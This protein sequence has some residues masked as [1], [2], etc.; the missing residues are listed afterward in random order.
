MNTTRPQLG[1]NTEENP[2]QKAERLKKELMAQVRDRI[3]G[4]PGA[5]EL[6][7]RFEEILEGSG[8]INETMA[9]LTDSI[10]L[11]ADG[12]IWMYGTDKPVMSTTLTAIVGMYGERMAAKEEVATEAVHE[13]I[14]AKETITRALQAARTAYEKLAEVTSTR[15]FV[16]AHLLLERALELQQEHGA[17]EQLSPFAYT[18]DWLGIH[19]AIVGTMQTHPDEDGMITVKTEYS[20]GLPGVQT[21]TRE[22]PLILEFIDE[23]IALMG[24]DLSEVL[25]N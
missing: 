14:K 22:I 19:E 16:E 21:I 15:H 11:N 2:T 4:E 12:V 3:Q 9:D 5:D 17:A 10:D 23:R 20:L 18:E 13:S 1:E 8:F 24:P 7:A 6:A 25:D